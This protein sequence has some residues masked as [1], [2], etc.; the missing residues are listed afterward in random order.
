MHYEEGDQYTEEENELAANGESVLEYEED[1]EE[2]LK[3]RRDQ[4]F[5][6]IDFTKRKC[7]IVCTLG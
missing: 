5:G 3:I 7:K 2:Y 6:E 1:E 4:V